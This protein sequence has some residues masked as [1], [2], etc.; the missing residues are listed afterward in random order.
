MDTWPTWFRVLAYKGI[1][2]AT[3]GNSEAWNHQF[4]RHLIKISSADNLILE[5]VWY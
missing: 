5:E 3:I 2:W 4:V 1:E